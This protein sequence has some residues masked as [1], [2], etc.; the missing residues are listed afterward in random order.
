M[1]KQMPRCSRR[2]AQWERSI[3]NPGERRDELSLGSAG[4]L[5]RLA[6]ATT[7]PIEKLEQP[8]CWEGSCQHSRWPGA[9]ALTWRACSQLRD[10]S[11]ESSVHLWGD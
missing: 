9:G 11:G 6:P 1:T 7:L 10:M 8:D 3:G 2:Y 4:V 5:E